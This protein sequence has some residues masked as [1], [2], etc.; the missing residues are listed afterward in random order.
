M[1]T[2]LDPKT[3]TTNQNDDY[4]RITW[5]VN[6]R[7]CHGVCR[8]TY[9]RSE[10]IV[11]NPK[12][13]YRFLDQGISG[14]E[15][16]DRR[17]NWR[18]LDQVKEDGERGC[19]K[20]MMIYRSCAEFRWMGGRRLHVECRFT[21][22]GVISL[23]IVDGYRTSRFCDVQM[24]IQV[25]T[26]KPAWDYI[27]PGRTP[28]VTRREEYGPLLA[29][30][31]TE[32]NTTH[33]DC[34]TKN[35]ILPH[36]V[37][38]VGS[39]TGSRIFLHES[40]REPKKDGR[41]VALSYCWGRLHPPKTT[42]EN[43]AQHQQDISF[44][45]LPRSFQDAIIVTRNLEIRYLWIDSLCI[46]QD[47]SP[48]WQ[49]ESSNMASYYSDAYLVIA[50]AQAGDPTQGFLDTMGS[51]SHFNQHPSTEIGQ[52]TNPDS[53]ISRIHRR[54]LDGES[55]TGR[56]HEVLRESPLNKRAWA[57]QENLLAKRIVHFTER[58]LLWECVEGLKCECMEVDAAASPTS[59]PADGLRKDQFLSLRDADETTNLQELW[60]NLLHRYS[61]LALSY[62][63][64]SLP[65]LSGLAK[66]WE[67]Q[68]AGKYLA[69]FWY[70]N[71]LE[72]LIWY[73]VFT[74]ERQRSRE[75]RAPSWSP[76]SLECPDG[77][78]SDRMRH[79]EFDY[80]HGRLT[81]QHAVVLDSG[82]TA[83]GADPTGQIKSAFLQLQGH[84]TWVE[85]SPRPTCMTPMR[86]VVQL[87]KQRESAY[88]QFDIKMDHSK[89]LTLLLILI[90]DLQRGRSIALVLKRSGD[91]YQR[92]GIVEAWDKDDKDQLA[93]GTEET[94]V[95]I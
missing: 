90:G 72:S 56:H 49:T 86:I 79:I 10:G 71:I 70:G 33:K 44:D 30:W 38:D 41:Y 50:A 77:W 68:G 34:T 92:V 2:Q 12:F 15:T 52:I 73:T 29:S 76:F 3:E 16:A 53:S 19:Y 42:K 67:S 32:C 1:N 9:M 85:T 64:D 14:L 48:D 5:P 83:A 43:L 24:Y 94:V 7:E 6:P 28:M 84:V 80:P 78:C 40:W 61:S 87:G 25:D 65:A 20:C 22:P 95:I 4:F 45:T 81:K 55:C 91:A 39:R 13:R 89:G 93:A 35:A 17:S 74:K 88:I 37:L 82:V 59:R 46:V 18:N 26:P 21:A 36:R 47:H 23:S 27:K 75:Y 31:I 63:S 60:L 54:K 51:Y 66:L 8:Y 62:K 58:E 11:Y 57:L 69:G